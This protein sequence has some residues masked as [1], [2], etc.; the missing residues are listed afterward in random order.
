MSTKQPTAPTQSTPAMAAPGF[1]FDLLQGPILVASERTRTTWIWLLGLPVLLVA[2]TVALVLYLQTFEAEEADRRRMA[3]AQ[4]LEQSTR[5]HFRRLETD[6]SVLAHQYLAN[7]DNSTQPDST[8]LLWRSPGVI[9]AQGWL[10]SDQRASP[11]SWPQN[12]ARWHVDARNADNARALETLHRITLG[13]RRASY[14]GPMLDDKGAASDVVWLAVPVFERGVFAGDYMAA[15]SINAAINSLVPNWFMT[16]HSIRPLLPSGTPL[17]NP[18]ASQP[19]FWAQLNLPGVEM[20]LDVRSLEPQIAN[21]PR[22]FLLVALVFLAG[23]FASLVALRRDLIKRHR[24]EA[25]LRAQV[26]LR[27][28]M[29]NAVTIGLRAW[30]LNGRILYVNQAFCQLVGFSATELI[31]RSAPLPY[32]PAEQTDE[33]NTVHRDVIAQGTQDAGVEVQF[34]H[35]SGRLVDVLIH[36]APLFDTHN[37]QL[38]WMSSVIDI[39]ER[40][41]N[42][43]MAAK[44]QERL[45]ASG[46]LVAMGEVA[47]TLAHELNQPLGALSGFANGLL[48][49][50]RNGRISIDE[51]A[52]VVERMDALSDKAGRIIQRVNAFARRL[53][54]SRQR[55]DLNQF[56]QDTLASARAGSDIKVSMQLGTPRVWVEADPLLLEQAVSNVAR[57]AMDWA[58]RGEFSP[59]IR[60]QLHIDTQNETPHV[61]IVIGDNGPGVPDSE[62]ATIFNAF[63]T[64]K[65]EGMGMGLAICRSVIE[66]H[67]GHIAVARDPTLGGAQFTLWLPLDNHPHS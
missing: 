17:N 19:H 54:M 2:G 42:Q 28:A 66:A 43:A 58:Q 5:F 45:E 59:Q 15:L 11:N 64:N 21:V 23:M 6:L 41:H 16:N 34:Q 37:S 51:I 10:S 63:H 57:N 35:R 61:G 36:E 65:P 40:K 55:L 31:G 12:L 26:A 13:L 48:N 4:W 53:E 22:L 50:I 32:W 67:H 62:L 52:P 30:D 7:A 25:Q 44:Q 49:R 33:L 56:L 27:K 9:L 18:P 29:E 8:G 24:I 38:G 47:S 14:A 20:A 39:S 3:D 1:D 46:R 60:V